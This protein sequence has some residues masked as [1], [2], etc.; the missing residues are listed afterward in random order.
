MRKPFKILSI[1][2]GGIKGLYSA[3]VLARLEKV[4]K[5]LLS[6]KFDLICGTSTGGIL[7]LA[8]A[9]KI[10]ME[11][12]VKFYEQKGPIIFDEQNK[13]SFLGK[14]YL[15]YK[16]IL[17]KGKYKSIELEAALKEVFGDK[18]I[19]DS[20]NLLC[21]PAYNVSMGQPR[22][23]KKDYADL[24]ADDVK[25]CVEVALATA[26]APTY[27]PIKE[28]NDTQYADGGLWA[29]NPTLVGLSEYM[30]KIAKM[31]DCDYDGVEILSISSVAFP[32][33]ETHKK[34][35]RSF[36]DWKDSIFDIFPAGQAS[37]ESFF[38]KE[39]IPYLKFPVRYERVQ[40]EMLSGEYSNMITLDNA[41]AKALKEL[42]VI[43][44]KTA[45]DICTK[46]GIK[47]FFK[48]DKT[49]KI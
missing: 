42:K 14:Y 38:F 3:V 8:I 37:F 6:D 20:N 9:M 2:G 21:I 31:P 29:N 19:C 48:T 43:G 36:W 32:K 23:F 46:S 24:N 33:G 18:K 27:F 25:S 40:N 16:Q 26:A 34:L 17:S 5:T 11:T 35:D 41:S 1:D 15:Y 39:L 45:A 10:P 28:I 12:A 30:F 22:V 47:D 13:R 7:A 44:K 4:F 49:F